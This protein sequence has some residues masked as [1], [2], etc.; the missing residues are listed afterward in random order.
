M[1]SV[2]QRPRIFGCSPYAPR[3]SFTVTDHV[4]WAQALA[5]YIF[6]TGGFPVL[7]QLYAPQWL[8]DEDPMER[9][10][11]LEWSR[12]LLTTVSAMLVLHLP[13]STGMAGEVS[14]ACSLGLPI[15]WVSLGQIGIGDVPPPVDLSPALAVEGVEALHRGASWA[16]LAHRFPDIT[17]AQW[18]QWAPWLSSRVCYDGP[19]MGDCRE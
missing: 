18:V 2:L 14:W 11:G 19:T 15:R 6:E 1:T 8:W 12:S 9:E 13:L 7:A 4:H 16:Q 17:M 3:A 5:R 10:A